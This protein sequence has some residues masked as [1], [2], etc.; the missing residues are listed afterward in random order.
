VPELITASAGAALFVVVLLTCRRDIVAAVA[1]TAIIAAVLLVP[2]FYVAE[3]AIKNGVLVATSVATGLALLRRKFDASRRR[4]TWMLA[5]YVAVTAVAT[6]LHPVTAQLTELVSAVLPGSCVAIIW[7]VCSPRERQYLI[8]FI[9]FTASA[10]AAY[11]TLEMVALAPRLWEN[12][13]VY[14]HQ[15]LSGL[16][17]GE[18]T[19]GHPLMLALF[20]I[21]AA[22]IVL[23]KQVEFGTMHRAWLFTLLS[24]GLLATGS[25][26]GLIVAVALLLFSLGGT[27]TAR[28]SLGAACATL[29]V[30]L[31]AATGFFSG[32]LVTNFLQGDSVGHRS[33]AIDAIPKLLAQHPTEV[34]VGNGAG[35][36]DD[37]FAEG[38]LQAG[39]F[40]AIDN[41]LITTIVTSGLLGLALLA[42]LVATALARSGGVRKP[43]IAVVV[44]FFT[45]DVLAWPAGFALFAL[46]IGMCFTRQSPPVEMHDLT[47]DGTTRN[48]LLRAPQNSDA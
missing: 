19:M 33:G 20:L 43:L 16:T 15:L 14:P 22:A 31:L 23:S 27:R 30:T 4:G 40:Y 38:L 6:A 17:R 46:A 3:P 37:I 1:G 5:T 13:I 41:Q 44:F 7:Y 25:R 24:I 36:V 11:A 34:L 9:V 8:K 45:F 35:S 48:P 10:E 42:A 47:A 28:V 32:D 21:F 12:P 39:N 2:T 29:L 18:G 26:S